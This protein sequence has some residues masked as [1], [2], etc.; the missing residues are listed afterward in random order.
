MIRI[1]C[2]GCGKELGHNSLQKTAGWTEAQYQGK[3]INACSYWCL[4]QA[5]NRHGFPANPTN[6]GGHFGAGVVVR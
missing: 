1:V 5:G 2:D 3:V 4:M 6:T